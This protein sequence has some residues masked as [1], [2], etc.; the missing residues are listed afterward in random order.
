MVD[1]D[2]ADDEEAD[3]IGGEAWPGLGELVRETP[4][5]VASTCRSSTSNVIATASTPSL[6]ASAR[7][8]SMTSIL[9]D[10]MVLREPHHTSGRPDLATTVGDGRWA[11]LL[12]TACLPMASAAVGGAVDHHA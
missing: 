10:Q 1:A 12:M 8:F 9:P 4:W 5:P 7:P 11:D 2:H 3:E 6:N